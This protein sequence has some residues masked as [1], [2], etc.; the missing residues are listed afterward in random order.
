MRPAHQRPTFSFGRRR[1]TSR[2]SRIVELYSAGRSSTEVAQALG[3]TS[4]N[5]LIVLRKLG[6]PIRSRREGRALAGQRARRRDLIAEA[7]KRRFG[8]LRAP[9]P[10]PTPSAPVRHEPDSFWTEDDIP[11]F[12]D[13]EDL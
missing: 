3:M 6:V 13:L 2:D 1:D 5:V 10:A 7:A 8:D 9:A 4:T 12:D 11:A